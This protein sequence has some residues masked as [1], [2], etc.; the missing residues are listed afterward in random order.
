MAALH[1]VELKRKTKDP[2]KK[3]LS[4]ERSWTFDK[5]IKLGG[6][7]KHVLCLPLPGKMI[8]FDGRI[9]FK[10]VGSTTK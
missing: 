9:F 1:T 7:F 10:G 2:S 5:L 4:L 8:Q 6:G 3:I